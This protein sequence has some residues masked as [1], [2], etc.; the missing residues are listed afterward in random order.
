MSVN[1]RAYMIYG[2]A[3][4]TSPARSLTTLASTTAIR[5][6]IYDFYLGSS[7]TPADNALLWKAQRFTAPGTNTAFTPVALDSGD[8]AATAV[9]GFA[10]GATDATYTAN[11]FL[12]W[13]A[14]NQRA[15]HRAILDPN[16]PMSA[17]AIG[18]NGIGFFVVHSSFT[19]ACDMTEFYYE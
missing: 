13:L 12:F 17:P 6:S 8:P 9:A 2:S 15:T 11:G 4:V 16:R 3:A 5:P 10:N 19:G 1:G 14:L 7:A 18:S